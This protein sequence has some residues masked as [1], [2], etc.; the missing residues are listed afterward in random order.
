MSWSIYWHTGTIKK[1]KTPFMTWILYIILESVVQWYLIEKKKITPNYW[2]VFIFR[3]IFAIAHGILILDVTAET[4]WNWLGQVALPIP[5]LFNT[6]LNTWRKM[7][8][9]SR[10]PLDYVGK[11]SG[12]LD[13]IIY[14]YNLQ[15]VYFWIT[16]ILF[17][18]AVKFLM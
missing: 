6:L 13:P 17:F 2:L 3:S 10:R 1:N 8:D 16:F 12:I 7:P 11:D 14:R 15:R 4:F 18:I 5:W 9:G